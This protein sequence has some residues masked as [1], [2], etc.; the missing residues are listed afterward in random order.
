MG[1]EPT[2]PTTP[3]VGQPPTASATTAYDQSPAY[4]V[5]AQPG[6]SVPDPNRKPHVLGFIALGVAV[7]GFIFAC[8][9]GALIVGWVLLPIA[10]V[11]AIVALFMK[12]AKWPAITGLILSI[13]GT[14]VG[15]V[16]FFTVVTT[17][18]DEAFDGVGGT[19]A[20]TEEASEAPADGGDA[21][22]APVPDAV[23]TLAFGDTMIYEDGVELT[24]SEPQPYTPSEFAAGADQA[25]NI[26][27]TMTITNNSTENLEPLPFPQLSS[28]GQ[29]SSEIFDVTEAGDIGLAP[30]NVI[31]PGQSVTWQSAWS[32]PIRTR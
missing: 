14:I 24:V 6:A 4:P 19:G 18:F 30:T 9:P 12:G 8:I 1:A 22:E 3:V 15:F 23:G 29:E 31:L 16:V 17:S 27:F 11:L 7:L 32:A 10:F 20:T 28:G 26:V 25:T 2:G 13:V 5:S 21:S